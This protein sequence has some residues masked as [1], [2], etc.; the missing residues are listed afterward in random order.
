M[1][2]TMKKYLIEGKFSDAFL[3]FLYSNEDF[4]FP[5]LAG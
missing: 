1:Q 4:L 3:H 2:N 5:S